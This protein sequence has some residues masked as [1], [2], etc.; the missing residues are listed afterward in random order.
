MKYEIG[1]RVCVAVYKKGYIKDPKSG[2]NAIILNKCDYGKY[3]V[4]FERLDDTDGSAYAN[5]HII[6][7][8]LIF[9]DWWEYN[10]KQKQID[11]HLFFK[12]Y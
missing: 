1:Q 11:E 6:D 4:L 12:D 5:T 8:Y 10:S 2:V 9:D 3:L 7:D